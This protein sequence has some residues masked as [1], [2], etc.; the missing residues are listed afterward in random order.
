MKQKKIAVLFGCIMFWILI[1]P[2]LWAGQVVTDEIKA[3]AK[4]ALNQEQ[5]LKEKPTSLKPNTVAVIN[6]GNK[7]GL[8]QMDILQKG[9]AV[10]LITDLSRVPSIQLVERVKTLAILNEW[11]LGDSGLIESNNQYRLGKLL[12]AEHVIGGDILKHKSDLFQ[13]NSNLLNVKEEKIFG[14]PQAEGELLEGL[15]LLEKN[16]LFEIIEELKI[17]LSQ[18]QVAALKNEFCTK[19]LDAL[20]DLFQAIEFS[21]MGDYESARLF[22]EKALQKDPDICLASPA[23][24]EIDALNLVVEAYEPPEVPERTLPDRETTITK[25][26]EPASLL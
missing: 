13:V 22:Y 20:L 12:S 25:D 26:R 11:G 7:T 14:Q 9:L 1:T 16:L 15:F 21:D 2:P 23:I 8:P 3:W 18:E 17:E 19:N 5:I 24:A 4:E 10:L 6:F